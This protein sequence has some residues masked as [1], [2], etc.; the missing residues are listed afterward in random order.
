MSAVELT[1]AHCEALRRECQFYVEQAVDEFG[2]EGRTGVDKDRAGH[3]K[4]LGEFA[5]ILAFVRPDRAPE[6]SEETVAVEFPGHLRSR[7]EWMREQADLLVKEIE[8]GSSG[9]DYD[10]S[11]RSVFAAYTLNR[12]LGAQEA[13]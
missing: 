11:A 3:M 2:S 6:T 9:A 7:L 12:V 13:A 5:D 8:V 1:A 4:R 10:E